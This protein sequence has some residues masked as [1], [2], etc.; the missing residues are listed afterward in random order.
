MLSYQRSPTYG[1][2]GGVSPI[3]TPLSI[4]VKTPLPSV[5]RTCPLVPVPLGNV[6][7]VDAVAADFNPL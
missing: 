7:V 6:N 5:A 4:Q 3:E 1:F 2:R